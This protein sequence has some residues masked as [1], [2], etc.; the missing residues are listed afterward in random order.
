MQSTDPGRPEAVQLRPA[1][2]PFVLRPIFYAMVP[3]GFMLGGSYF[4]WTFWKSVLGSFALAIPVIAV[5]L[6]VVVLVERVVRYGKT[7]Y[8]VGPERIIVET[9]TIFRSRKVELDL[10][11]V[12]LVEWNSP[13]LLRKFYDVG[14]VTAQEAGSAAQPAKIAYVE[15]PGRLYERIGEHM[16][17]RGFS[18]RREQRIR[19][20]EPGHLGAVVD[21]TASFIALF[22]A[23]ILVGVQFAAE[24]L[25]LL[26]GEGPS[27]LQ[28]V[29]G[30]YEVFAESTAV[31]TL[32]RARIG[33]LVLGTVAVA[34]TGFGVFVAYLDLL[35]R[36]YTLYDDVI[37]YVD[38]FL[39][40]TR[41]YIPLEN[42]ADTEVSRPF[43]KRILGLSDVRI[44]SQGAENSISFASTPNGP[45]F[46]EAIEGLVRR[47]EAA[48]VEQAR[49]EPGASG[50]MDGVVAAESTGET[51]FELQPEPLRAAMRGFGLSTLLI[52]GA[53]GFLF[54]FFGEPSDMNFMTAIG[55]WGAVVTALL[56]LALTAAVGGF[57]W[58]AK[59]KRT[60]LAVEER[61]VRKTFDLFSR[62]DRRF[63]LERITSITVIRNPLDRMLGTMTVRFRSIGSNEDLDFWG[64]SDDTPLLP[65]LRER[66]GFD[67][68]SRRTETFDAR[69]G[70]L[71]PEFHVVDAVR[72]RAPIY[73][74]LLLPFVAGGIATVMYAPLDS[75]AVF[76]VSIG[77]PLLG[78]AVD[79]GLRGLIQ[80]RIRGDFRKNHVEVS[81]GIFRHYRH[82]APIEH[83]KAV[84]S[85]RYPG[86]RF[87]RLTCR[88]AGFPI[89]VDHAAEIERLHEYVDSRLA[90]EPRSRPQPLGT[91]APH[92]PTEMLRSSL[93]A[94]TVIGIPVLFV[95]YAY[96]RRVEYMVEPGRV[97]A[98]SGLYF[99]RRVTVLFGR[100]D[101]IESKKSFA[102]G[103]FD[104][105][106]V[107]VFTVGSPQTDLVLRSVRRLDG[108]VE[109][110]RGQLG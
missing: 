103:V 90:D 59:A 3:S 94:A 30:N 17:N 73:A 100:V 55:L 60:F 40:E 72:A 64:I 46:A 110:V 20:E 88:T 10:R 51:V 41:K 48:G 13:W 2:R 86:S 68:D 53:V 57:W 75:R 12:T 66:F 4:F 99:A 79:V 105:Y 61:G 81:G 95:L 109:T 39:N 43:F 93:L 8:E 7:R 97:V 23:V 27:L 102:H 62:N 9:G 76:A 83:V 78:M 15:H 50:T 33:A 82:F 96:Y 71:S 34:L 35:H 84:E 77:L 44:S 52:S 49:E 89:K 69:D 65:T 85:V 56:A 24:A 6:L 92:L 31:S 63:S 42:L 107:E 28:L 37:D 14:H 19:Q 25:P 29:M 22:W 91:Y 108:A 101:H 45:A 36:T 58:F 16:R 80:S 106:D 67:D 47:I 104:T 32:V 18:M 26:I 70:R 87:G 98:D 21:L 38:G 5:T 1:V 54:D 74:L 11:N